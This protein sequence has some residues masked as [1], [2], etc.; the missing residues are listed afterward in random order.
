MNYNQLCGARG[1]HNIINQKEKKYNQDFLLGHSITFV[2]KNSLDKNQWVPVRTVETSSTLTSHLNESLILSDHFVGGGILD[3]LV[4]LEAEFHSDDT[5]PL[6]RFAWS[7]SVIW[8]SDSRCFDVFFN[9]FV[10]FTSV[11]VCITSTSAIALFRFESLLFPIDLIIII[12][13]F[14]L[15]Q[16]F[17]NLYTYSSIYLCKTY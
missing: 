4:F 7:T 8:T 9:F 13:L 14:L 16:Q 11:T 17:N 2:A 12:E 15:F 5:Y 10:F 3:L 1:S 6:S